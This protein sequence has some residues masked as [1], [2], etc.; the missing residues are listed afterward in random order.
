MIRFT[1]IILILILS[2]HAFADE[3]EDQIKSFL[4]SRVVIDQ[5][6]F[7]VASSKLSLDS[8]RHLD[9]LVPLLL[10]QKS[11]SSLFRVEGFASQDGY[12]A[13]NVSLSMSRALAVHNYLREKHD[14]T[15]DVFLTGFGAV[16]T[17]VNTEKSRRVDITVYQKPTEVMAL[18][19][20]QSPVEKIIV[21]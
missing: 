2:S 19:N 13:R 3:S 9:S 8:Q 10:K 6:Y 21:K 5:V 11:D 20:D 12:P 15:L 17:A 4:Q 7:E 1:L 16:D 18:F 14:L